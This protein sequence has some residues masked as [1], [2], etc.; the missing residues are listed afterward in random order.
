MSTSE[1]PATRCSTN[2]VNEDGTAV[3]SKVDI[4]TVT[5]SSVAPAGAFL[6]VPKRFPSC[7][8]HGHDSDSTKDSLNLPTSASCDGVF[9]AALVETTSA[10]GTAGTSISSSEGSPVEP[11]SAGDKAVN[12]SRPGSPYPSAHNSSSPASAGIGSSRLV[13]VSRSGGL[14]SQS[15]LVVAPARP[16]A[17]GTSGACSFPGERFSV[18][19]TSQN[20]DASS[21]STMSASL[22]PLMSPLPDFSAV[23][24]AAGKKQDHH[25]NLLKSRM[26]TIEE[27]LKNVTMKTLLTMDEIKELSNEAHEALMKDDVKTVIENKMS[28][29]LLKSMIKEAKHQQRKV[30]EMYKSLQVELA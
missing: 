14:G 21:P 26:E 23:R 28:I 3:C 18:F 27:I 11:A 7:D 5:F 12:P 2:T 4:K 24:N 6:H 17:S 15:P 20:S 25:D 1:T 22:I 9:S 16:P 30:Y 29:N 8:P 19:P 13:A 10:A